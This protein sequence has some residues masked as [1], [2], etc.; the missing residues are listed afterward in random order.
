MSLS[1]RPSTLTLS[2]TSLDRNFATTL[3]LVSRRLVLHQRSTGTPGRMAPPDEATNK[4]T[5][6]DLIPAEGFTITLIVDITEPKL[7][8]SLT[9][10]RDQDSRI[11]RSRVVIGSII[12]LY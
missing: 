11:K 7:W 9:L 10:T 5:N 1:T 12:S 4:A 8:T 3:V 2:Y 6:I